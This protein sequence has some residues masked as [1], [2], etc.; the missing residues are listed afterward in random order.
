MKNDWNNDETIEFEDDDLDEDDDFDD[1]EDFEED[2]VEEED[3]D[4]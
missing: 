2:D 4:N 1:D 3:D